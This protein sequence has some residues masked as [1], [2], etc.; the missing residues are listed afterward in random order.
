MSS[1]ARIV[2]AGQ[3]ISAL[4]KRILET[5]AL[6]GVSGS[7]LSLSLFGSYL[8]SDEEA[9]ADDVDLLAIVEGNRF[10]LLEGKL[11]GGKCSGDSE[12]D[13]VPLHFGLSIKGLENFTHGIIDKNS[14]FPG[15][16]QLPVINRTAIALYE[17]HLPL[18]G[19]VFHPNSSVLSDN[20]LAVASDL[21][22]N[23]FSRFYVRGETLNPSRRL[24]KIVSRLYEACSY[25]EY[26]YPEYGVRSENVLEHKAKIQRGE[27]LLDDLQRYWH[28]VVGLLNRSE[29]H[30]G[31]GFGGHGTD[32]DRGVDVT[33]DAD[34][35]S[36]L[37]EIARR[38]MN[39]E[40]LG[41]FLPV[42][43][44]ITDRSGRLVATGLREKQEPLGAL[45]PYATHAEMSAIREAEVRGFDDW[46]GSTMYVN[47]EPCYYCMRALSDF[48]GFRRVVYGIDDPTLSERTRNPEAALLC[49]EGIEAFRGE[50]I[51]A[52]L[53]EMFQGLFERGIRENEILVDVIAC[54][55]SVA[56][57]LTN[58]YLS[59]FGDR[60]Q[61]VVL[62]ANR[63]YQCASGDML[64][65]TVCFHI[66]SSRL[67]ARLDKELLLYVVGGGVQRQW[68]ECVLR[69]ENMCDKLTILHYDEEAYSVA[70]T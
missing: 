17:R 49:R 50:P 8:F 57:L 56:P 36:Q 12:R 45:G 37:I 58:A 59:V 18:W 42:V 43:A 54:E 28:I 47:L 70:Q 69:D 26:F 65:P 64:V 34:M 33:Q 53:N 32:A 16:A 9:S 6:G 63:L 55:K 7:I 38:E 3:A 11:D 61:I 48:Y 15:D 22:C 62:D 30:L 2:V 23:A 25:I 20:V 60:P 66:D 68:L 21:L 39:D 1:P 51:R 46:C 19:A 31:H 14:V 10:D 5:S 44:Q 40:N 35:M 52:S 41:A 4:V 67:S 29:S 27:Y 13:G 24:G